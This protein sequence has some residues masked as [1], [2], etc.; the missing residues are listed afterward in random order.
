MEEVDLRATPVASPVPRDPPCYAMGP[1]K[2]LGRGGTPVSRQLSSP[3]STGSA[4]A[5]RDMK[6][7]FHALASEVARDRNHHV[8]K[9]SIALCRKLPRSAAPCLPQMVS[10]SRCKP[11]YR[12][13]CQESPAPSQGDTF[14]STS[15]SGL[16]CSSLL[17][18]I[19]SVQVRFPLGSL[20]KKGQVTCWLHHV[21]AIRQTSRRRGQRK[22]QCHIV[23]I[24]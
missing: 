2:A 16:R 21:R 14:R 15:V 8:K 11:L 24:P 19:P 4:A 9:F 23:Y 22:T 13:W 17:Q 6:S 10:S 18:L 3:V 7:Y 1:M 12:G 5:G 20:S